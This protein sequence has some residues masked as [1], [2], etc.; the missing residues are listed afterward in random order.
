[1]SHNKEPEKREKGIEMSGFSIVHYQKESIPSS[2]YYRHAAT[3]NNDMTCSSSKE[4]GA[5][6]HPAFVPVSWD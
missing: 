2:T 3:T 1:L 6:I 4:I 5:K